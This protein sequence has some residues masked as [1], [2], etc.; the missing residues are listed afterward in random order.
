MSDQRTSNVKNL[1]EGYVYGVVADVNEHKFGVVQILK[2]TSEA[3]GTAE[4]GDEYSDYPGICTDVDGYIRTVTPNKSGA[5]VVLTIDS[6]S[7]TIPAGTPAG[8]GFKIGSDKDLQ[9]AFVISSGG[10][11]GFIVEVVFVPK[12]VADDY[13]GY[14]TD[15]G[16]TFPEEWR[17]IYDHGKLEHIKHIANIERRITFTTL[18]QNF[19][20]GFHK[21]PGQFATILFEI[22]EH[23]GALVTEKTYYGKCFATE[24]NISRGTPDTDMT[25]AADFRYDLWMSVGE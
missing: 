25:S 5:E 10:I 17:G 21:F 24:P 19:N 3:A 7:I 23:Q 9:G 4:N 11:A 1:E 13:I 8:R 16:D 22:K 2:L 18:F 14:V 20:S 12:F 6:E 15:F